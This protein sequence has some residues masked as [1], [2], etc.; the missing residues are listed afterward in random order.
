MP[1]QTAIFD[2][3]GT[4]L[5]TL[6]DLYNAV[7]HSLVAYGLPKRSLAEVRLFTGNGIRRLIDLSVPKGT[8]SH[9]TDQVFGEFKTYYD[10]H[11]LD[12]TRPYT[13]MTEV[14][15]DLRAANVACAVVSNKADFAVQGIIDHFYPSKFDYVMGERA[16]IMRKPNRDMIDVILRDLGRSA[17]GMA[18]VGD[19]EV[20]IET[21]KNR[22]C[23]C[24]SCSW[25]FRD[26][27]WLVEHGATTIV[28]TPAELEAKILA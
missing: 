16:G 10:A 22:G 21:A 3:D 8:P 18:Y 28:D 5:N 25:G 12:T 4:L 19:S 13:G 27:E 6:D 15:D 7:N 24:L 11:K 2:L 26:R 20:D 1:Y 17:D 14:I 23:P 9:L